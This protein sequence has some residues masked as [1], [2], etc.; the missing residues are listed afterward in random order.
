VRTAPAQ[1]TAA[2]VFLL[3]GVPV[4]AWFRARRARDDAAAPATPA[5]AAKPFR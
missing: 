3:L 4:Y 1:A 5:S 2:L